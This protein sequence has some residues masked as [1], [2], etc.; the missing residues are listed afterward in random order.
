MKEL[1]SYKAL[2]YSC[3]KLKSF[4]VVCGGAQTRVDGINV[5]IVMSKPR[6]NMVLMV[7]MLVGI[8]LA[9]GI[10]PLA[11]R[12]E[13]NSQQPSF[14]KRYDPPL[15]L[16]ANQELVISGTNQAN[17]VI[18]LVVR[19]D[20]ALSKN[21][22]S[23]VNIERV[24]PPG[25]F[26]LRFSVQGLRTPSKRVLN[27]GEIRRMLIFPAQGD[28]MPHLQSVGFES[29][30]QLPDGAVGWD[31]GIVNSPVFPGFQAINPKDK[32]LRGANLKGIYR[33]AGDAL[34]ADG[35]KGVDVVEMPLAN[36]VWTISLWL[37]DLGEWEYLP[38]P[39]QRHIK[40]NG[41][42]ILSVRMDPKEWV[43]RVYLRGRPLEAVVNGDPWLLFGSRR[44]GLLTFPLQVTNGRLVLELSGD[45]AVARYLAGIL[46][47]PGTNKTVLAEV[48]LKRK[49]Q[50][51]QT[52]RFVD[53]DIRQ[54]TKRLKWLEPATAGGGGQGTVQ[55]Y[56][57][58]PGTSV[59]MDFF[60][61][62]PRDDARPLLVFQPPNRQGVH[63]VGE[64]RFGH[65]RFERPNA[66]ATLMVLTQNHL[67]GDLEQLRLVANIPRRINIH[68]RVP[69][70]APPG[71]YFGNLQVMSHGEVLVKA[72][73]LEVLPVALPV[74]RQSVGIYL[75]QA[76]YWN[77]FSPL[78]KD[79]ETSASC[80]LA[81]LR[82]LGLTGLAP[83]LST[84]NKNRDNKFLADIRRLDQQGFNSPLLAYTPVKR[85]LSN[86]SPGK[87]GQRLAAVQRLLQAFGLPSPVWAIADEPDPDEFEHIKTVASAL[88]A[89]MP[90]AKLAGQL[91]NPQ[92]KTL[93]K[94]LDVALVN[95]G[96]GVDG[97]D[98][99]S[100]RKAG[101]TPWFYNMP[102]PRLA[103]GFYLWRVG[104][105]GYL[106][107]H[108]RMPTADPFDP[109]DGREADIQFLFSTPSPCPKTQDVHAHL[110]ELVEGILDLRWLLWLDKQRNA[111]PKAAE[112]WKKL[113]R[114]VPVS[115]QD[116][117]ALPVEQAQQWRE[118]II[119]LVQ[120]LHAP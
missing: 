55:T 2:P 61:L 43:K 97:E 79:G 33:S 95:P 75:E 81:F 7:F 34:I 102:K 71:I 94:Y 117:M 14:N 16:L 111:Q 103:A 28:P 19:L 83:P 51:M 41:K 101:I 49:N 68:L 100:L 85:L 93:L 112:L 66:S 84:P 72:I 23:R 45:G 88:H 39:L 24:L 26:T 10:Y 48:L 32:H 4:T 89:A 119:K 47:E 110:F 60:L 15:V 31:F 120:Q 22:R 50:F 113:R 17:S 46:A 106:Q 53:S 40:A 20:D 99:D 21:Y 5:A 29:G 86:L 64:I 59:T 1:L 57:V 77:W 35:I 74:P 56:Q 104:V 25:P 80:D 36:G 78:R 92:Q 58:A 54:Q 115:W 13:A 90:K 8:L 18:T 108:G 27:H 67:R 98:L 82:R 65:W 30:F 38:H 6:A 107:W 91:N 52:W 63:S 76:P 114:E 109:T 9:A 62:A 105:E 70:D 69:Q 12:G 96:F 118:E 73:N 3:L 42:T 116:V 11:Q 37:E 44:G 87:V